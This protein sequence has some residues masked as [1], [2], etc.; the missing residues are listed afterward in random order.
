MSHRPTPRSSFL[1]AATFILAAA[2]AVCCHAQGQVLNQDQEVFVHNLPSLTAH[3]QDPSDIL[4]ASLETVFHDHDVCCGKNSALGDSALAADAKSLKD[5]AEKLEG[6]HHLSDGRPIKVVAEYVAPDAINSGRLI[7]TM[8][9][10]QPVLMEW[11]SRLY[12][13]HGVVYLWTASGDPTSGS[14]SRM[15]VI[16][17]LL[18]TD[19]RFSDSRREVIFDRTTDDLSKVQG[20]LFLQAALQ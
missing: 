6:R 3:S 16:H 9:N 14:F 19:T 5:V 13:V 15:T 20:M 7:S 10:Q 18:L 4:L 8:M 1:L 12:V 2:L 11:N 17:K